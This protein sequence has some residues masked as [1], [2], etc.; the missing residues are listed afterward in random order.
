MAS[1]VGQRADIA[2]TYRQ[3]DGLNGLDQCQFR[4]EYGQDLRERRERLEHE[5][6][7]PHW[8]ELRRS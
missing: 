4:G 2:K 7:E 3:T 1:P 5:R 8:R 6:H